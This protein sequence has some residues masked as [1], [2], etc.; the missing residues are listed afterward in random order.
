MMM[1]KKA[2]ASET[3]EQ[4]KWNLHKSARRENKKIFES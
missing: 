1:T 3:G 2:I 4:K